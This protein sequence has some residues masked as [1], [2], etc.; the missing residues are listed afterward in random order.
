MNGKE[1]VIVE[2]TQERDREAIKSRWPPPELDLV[3]KDDR[4]IRFKQK[5]IHTEGRHTTDGCELKKLSPIER[6]ER[7]RSAVTIKLVRLSRAHFRILRAREVKI[8]AFQIP[9][10][11][12]ESRDQVDAAVRCG[13]WRKW[14]SLNAVGAIKEKR[15]QS[16]ARIA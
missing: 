2:V 10:S 9:R 8:C 15:T 5:G 7:Q 16:S 11:E 14:E 13:T 1:R 4:T 3:I 6:E 12:A